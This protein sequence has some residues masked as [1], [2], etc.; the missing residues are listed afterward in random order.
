MLARLNDAFGGRL[1]PGQP[2]AGGLEYVLTSPP[3]DGSTG[4]ALMGRPYR[5]LEESL[6]DS[7]RWWAANG[8][9]DRKLAGTL[10]P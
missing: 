7:I 4:E 9:I 1:I 6:T 10:A 5:L 2:T 3:I 8:V